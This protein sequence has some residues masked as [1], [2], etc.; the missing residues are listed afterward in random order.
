MSECVVVEIDQVPGME[1]DLPEEGGRT[2]EEILWCWQ[3]REEVGRQFLLRG[4]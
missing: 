2:L 3:R 4:A 1:W